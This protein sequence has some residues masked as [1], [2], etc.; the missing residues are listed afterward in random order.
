MVFNMTKVQHLEKLWEFP[1]PSL[2]HSLSLIA[3]HLCSIT[4]LQL[5]IVMFNFFLSDMLELRYVSAQVP[6]LAQTL[7]HMP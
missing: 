1:S 2:S 5:Y 7:L 4:L 3:A 6:D